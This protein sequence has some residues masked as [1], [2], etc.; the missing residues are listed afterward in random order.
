MRYAMARLN[1]LETGIFTVADGARLIRSSEQKIRGWIAGYP[2]RGE[3]IL[4]N[5]LQVLDGKLAFSFINLMEMRFLA[6]FA[7]E[8]I[9]LNSLRYM[10][11]EAQKILKRQHPFATNT[12]FKT[13]GK[14]IYAEIIERSG[15]KKLYNLYA[16]NFEM[17]PVIE[18]TLKEE[19]VYDPTGAARH[20]R[21]RPDLAPNIIIHPK[22]AFGQPTLKESGVPVRALFG[23]L[24]SGE[25]VKSVARWFDVPEQHVREAEKFCRDLALAA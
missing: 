15:D 4:K 1:L 12:L 6:F 19:I 10:A 25:T 2:R 3:P 5:E 7:D 23:A 22:R 13:D 8:G 11:R 14:R 9:H 16:R 24:E 18:R 17:A 20:W 21:P